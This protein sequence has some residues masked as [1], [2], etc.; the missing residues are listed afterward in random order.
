LLP[1]SKFFRREND[2][3]GARLYCGEQGASSSRQARM[4]PALIVRRWIMKIMAVSIGILVGSLAAL[5]AHAGPCTAEIDTLTQARASAGT[6]SAPGVP[7]TPKL[8][9][10][11][12]T[13]GTLPADPLQPVQPPKV[14]GSDMVPKAPSTSGSLPPNPLEPTAATGSKVTD[15]GAMPQDGAG[16]G[17][18]AAALQRARE[19]DQAGD[20][21]GCLAEV[22]KAKDL[23]VIQ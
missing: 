10:A 18:A 12:A 6:D 22:A 19:L 13:T 14:P 9:K 1:G 17:G 16:G 4:V 8:P 23:M 3:A 7:A 5:P 2:P 20:E 11:P 21:A 15:P